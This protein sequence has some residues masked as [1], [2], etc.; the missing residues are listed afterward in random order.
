MCFTRNA[1]VL[2]QRWLTIE[3][4]SLRVSSGFRLCIFTKRYTR[5][6]LLVMVYIAFGACFLVFF[7][8]SSNLFIVLTSNRMVLVVHGI[9]RPV[10]SAIDKSY[11]LVL[12]R[13]EREHHAMVLALACFPKG[14]CRLW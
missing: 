2:L 4:E 13:R 3:V 14:W 6:P 12:E 7:G 8:D 10:A 9:I 5:R 11:M 1:Q